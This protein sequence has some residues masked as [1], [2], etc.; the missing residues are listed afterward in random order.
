MV[1]TLLTVPLPRR[2]LDHP[3]PVR[4][5]YENELGWATV[6]APAQCPAGPVR[7]RVGERFDVLDVP[8]EAGRAAL[9]H[10]AQAS[11]VAL[12]GDRMR[13]LVAAGS[14]EELPGLL[15]WLEWGALAL[16]LA[17]TGEGGAM[18]APLPLGSGPAGLRPPGDPGALQ[19]AAVWLRPPEPGCEVEASLPTLSAVGGGGGAPDLVRLVDTVATQCHRLRLRRTDLRPLRLP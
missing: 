17:V 16:D 19:G 15:E 13:L 7:L 4:G 18:D 3:D 5:W 12:Q 10:L 9:R 11:P 8:A 2:P 14:A 6:P 1:G